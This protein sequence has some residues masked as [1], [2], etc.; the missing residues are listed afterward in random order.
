VPAGGAVV[1][2]KH[3]T[4][5][6]ALDFF[7]V[8]PRMHSKN[9]GYRAWQAIEARYPHTHAWETHTPYFEKRNLHFY[10]NKCG[11]KIVAFYNRHHLDLAGRGPEAGLDEF[12]QF[13]K[14]MMPPR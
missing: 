14:I 10:V 12:F 9:I 7:F 11:F 5:R 8:S 4:G 13:E 3:A 2:I 6:N 1:A